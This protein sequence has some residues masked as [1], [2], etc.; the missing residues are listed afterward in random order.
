MI[1][2]V[3]YYL[4]LMGDIDLMSKAETICNSRRY[5]ASLTEP[6]LHVNRM[7]KGTHISKGW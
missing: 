5:P 1:L 6:I 7:T 4:Y 2:K 3:D